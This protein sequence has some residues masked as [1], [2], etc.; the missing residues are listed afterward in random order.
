MATI[1]GSAAADTI[2]PSGISAGVSG[3]IPGSGADFI[4]GL[5]GNDVLDGGGGAN[6]LLGGAGNDTIFATGLA[7]LLDGGDGTDTYVYVGSDWAFIDLGT[8]ATGTVLKA[9]VTDTISG[10]QAVFASPGN[11][12]LKGTKTADTLGGGEG[13]DIIDGRGGFDIVDYG[14]HYGAAPTVGAIVNLSSA[15]VT[16]GGTAYAAAPRATAG[17]PSTRCRTSRARSAPLSATR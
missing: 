7:E 5:G 12:T 9:S 2:S 14:T 13:D 10:F 11:D 16:V 3:S 8:C 1:Y 17:A 15:S 4:S 6:T